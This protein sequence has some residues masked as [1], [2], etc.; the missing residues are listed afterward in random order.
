VDSVGKVYLAW[1]WREMLQRSWSNA[2]NL[3]VWFI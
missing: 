2:P 3:P 1:W